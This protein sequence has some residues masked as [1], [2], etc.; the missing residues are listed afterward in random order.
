LRQVNVE[1]RLKWALAHKDWTVEDWKRVIWSD[2]CMIQIGVD[3]RRQWVIRLPGEKLNPKYV[4]KTFK[5]ARVKVMVWACFTG[6]RIGP[7][8]ICDEGGIGAD[9]YE[10]ILYDGLFGLIDDI[11]ELPDGDT[12]EVAGDSTYVF[13][14]DNASCHKAQ[15][16]LDFLAQHQV[17]VMI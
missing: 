14:Q 3:P 9:E 6:D 1:A 15:E 2:E 16:V 7:L 4:K 17:P 8:I 5:D 11:L 13:M 10:D 12:I